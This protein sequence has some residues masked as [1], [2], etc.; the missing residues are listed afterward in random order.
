MTDRY[1]AD[2]H[3]YPRFTNEVSMEVTAQRI[4]ELTPPG[5]ANWSEK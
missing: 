1:Q 3:P 5:L 2:I 4:I